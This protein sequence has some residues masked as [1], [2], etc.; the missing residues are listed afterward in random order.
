[1]YKKTFK[2][3][4]KNHSLYIIKSLYIIRENTLILDKKTTQMKLLA[5]T[6]LNL[7][8]FFMTSRW[9]TAIIW[10]IEHWPLFWK[11]KIDKK[12]TK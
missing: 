11:T 7:F 12:I 8:D 5:H 9:Q 10:C 4:N 3:K 2:D 1:M 6:A